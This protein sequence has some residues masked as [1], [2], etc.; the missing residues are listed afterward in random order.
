[1]AAI[2]AL[3]VFTT[4]TAV[5]AWYAGLRWQVFPRKF[6]AVDPNSLYRSGQISPRLIEPTLRTYGIDL[7]LFMSSDNLQREDVRAEIAA[8]QRLGIRRVNLPLGGNGTGDP[9]AYVAALI[10]IHRARQRGEQVL[11][12]CHTGSQRTGGVVALHRIL[13]D[14]WTPADARDELLAFGHSPRDNPALIPYLNANMRLIAGRLVD[15]GVLP[16]LP[17]PIPQLPYP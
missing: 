17:E 14:G 5:T 11:V 1:M 6:A 4:A 15:A 16:S 13:L 12:H 8:C 7:V 3:L 10:E 2:G 9:E